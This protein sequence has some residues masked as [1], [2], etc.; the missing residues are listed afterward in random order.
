MDEAVRQK[1]IEILD[2]NRIMTIATMRPDGWPQATMVGYANDGLSLYF[3]C[4]RDSQKASNLSKDDR[5]SLSV[6]NDPD[7]VME[8]NAL[9]MA[10]RAEEVNDPDELE[11]VSSLLQSKYPWQEGTPAQAPPAE[12]TCVFRLSPEVIS[13]IDYTKGFAHTDLVYC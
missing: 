2:T 6:G 13:V 12:L 3:C 11:K 8:I 9:S 4:G 10:A 7:Q 1:I 5:V